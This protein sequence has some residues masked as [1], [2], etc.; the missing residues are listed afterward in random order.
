MIGHLPCFV[1]VGVDRTYLVMRAARLPGFGNVL[2]VTSYI[3]VQLRYCTDRVGYK[4]YGQ[5]LS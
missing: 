3:S 5:M 2:R 4:P 1:E